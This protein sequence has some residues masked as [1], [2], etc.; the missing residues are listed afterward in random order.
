MPTIDS[1]LTFAF[2]S[3]LLSI[4][5]GPSVLYI[6]ARS[7]SQGPKAGFAAA[8][9]MA[10][11][12]FVYVLATALGIAVI[13]QYSPLAYTLLKLLGAAYLIYLGY[14]YFQSDALDIEQ[15]QTMTSLSK[16]KIFRQSIVVELTNPKTA[17]FFLAFLPQFV[18]LDVGSV[19][20][21]LIILGTVYA[22]VALSCDLCVAL[23]SGR[24]G[25]WLGQHQRAIYWQDR[26][27]G[28]VLFGLG[29]FIC[30]EAFDQS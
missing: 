8:G 19:T 11:G 15:K 14:Q 23:A 6:M 2:V 25:V 12:S 10:V 28:S 26:L 21:Q 18:S 29:I 24:L 27:A 1:I 13:F 4:S 5:P 20:L 3:F 9:G 17:L 16:A 30:Y 7:I 22:V